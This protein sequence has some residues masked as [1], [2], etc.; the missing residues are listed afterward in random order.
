MLL[1]LENVYLDLVKPDGS[2]KERHRRYRLTPH[3]F[4][5]WLQVFTILASIIGEKAPEN[6]S[7]VFCY[8]DSIGEAYRTYGGMAWLRFDEQFHQRKGGI[9]RILGFR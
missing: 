5:N 7:V 6:C 8:M 1:P 3:T 4:A 2:K 9:T